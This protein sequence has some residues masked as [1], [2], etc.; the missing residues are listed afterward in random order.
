MVVVV[1][2]S[3]T[4]GN[5]Q[6]NA[7]V[8][9]TTAL[10]YVLVFLRAPALLQLIPCCYSRTILALCWTTERDFLCINEEDNYECRYESR[11]RNGGLIWFRAQNRLPE[12]DR[13]N[14]SLSENHIFYNFYKRSSR[15]CLSSS[16]CMGW[17]YE[18][19]EARANSLHMAFIG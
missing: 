11:S 12:A 16:D 6:N 3:Y 14:Y 9:D 5:P 13:T 15:S 19:Y 8:T 17:R 18:I 4:S 10:L 7:T 2:I 1:Y